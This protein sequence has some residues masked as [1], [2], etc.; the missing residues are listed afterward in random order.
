MKA[1]IHK[2]THSQYVI[3][4]LDALFD[5]PIFRTTDF[6]RT[7]GIHKPTAMGLLRQ[8][9]TTGILRELRP[10]SGR[11]PAVLCFSELIN[12]AEGKNVL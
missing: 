6:V 3:H 5:R 8:L 2:I 11:R 7:T 12:I 4:V 1:R 10:G 9:K